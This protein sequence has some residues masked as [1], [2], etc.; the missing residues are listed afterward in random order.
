MELVSVESAGPHLEQAKELFAEDW[1]SFGFTP[2][3]QGFDQELRSLPGASALYRS[4]GFR[5]TAPYLPEPTPGAPCLELLL[6]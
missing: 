6:R 1:T 5:D 2:C 4:P 3:F